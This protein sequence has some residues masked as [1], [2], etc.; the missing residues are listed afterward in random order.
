MMTKAHVFGV[1]LDGVA[2]NTP[3]VIA[4]T[5]KAET[6]KKFGVS[7]SILPRAE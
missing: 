3:L 2:V 1:F 5:K 6:K 4:P 7:V